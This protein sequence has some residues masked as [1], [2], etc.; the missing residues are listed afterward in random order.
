MMPRPPRMKVAL[1]PVGSHEN[2]TLGEMLPSWFFRS[3]R[4]RYGASSGMPWS[5]GSFAHGTVYLLFIV[6]NSASCRRPSESVKFSR[7]R[8]SSFRYTPV[9]TPVALASASLVPFGSVN[10]TAIDAVFGSV[11]V[12][13]RKLNDPSLLLGK[14]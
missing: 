11:D 6:L 7:M 3:P 14:L 13:V 4:F 1:R 9:V 12:S 2:D 8:H 5:T 10:P